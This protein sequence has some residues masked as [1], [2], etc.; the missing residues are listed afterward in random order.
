[1]ALS[2]VGAAVL[3]SM[4]LA[5]DGA[6]EKPQSP[7][8]TLPS[9]G[10][11][12]GAFGDSAKP[13]TTKP[14]PVDTGATGRHGGNPTAGTTDTG[15]VSSTGAGTTDTATASSRNSGGRGQAGTLDTASATTKGWVDPHA[16]RPTA[17]V[18]DTAGAPPP[19]SVGL[20][21]ITRRVSRRAGVHR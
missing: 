12:S 15:T 2:R 10:A 11:F 18:Y 6:K 4:I 13:D 1:M 14:P 20:R 8:D 17:G 3:A 21:R 7:A 9:G 5:C 19:A 16:L